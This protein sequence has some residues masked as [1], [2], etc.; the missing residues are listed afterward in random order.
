M[1]GRD[2]DLIHALSAAVHPEY[3]SKQADTLLINIRFSD[4]LV[5]HLALGYGVHDRE[6]RTPK[7]Y[8]TSGTL[9]LT[10]AGIE[11]W[12]DGEPELL[13]DIDKRDD[14]FAAE[15]ELFS[16][17]I[18]GDVAAKELVRADALESVF[19]LAILEAA[20]TSAQR[21]APVQIGGASEALRQ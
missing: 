18:S 19:D 11:R 16:R 12:S 17:A 6:S 9:A 10:R 1:V 21:G 2:V 4:G 3:L 8:G 20:L 15:W 13:A 14:G 5:G 7:V